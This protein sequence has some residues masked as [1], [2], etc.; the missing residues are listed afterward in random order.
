MERLATADGWSTYYILFEPGKTYHDLH[1]EFAESKA[2]LKQVATYWRNDGSFFTRTRIDPG[3]RFTSDGTQSE[4]YPLRWNDGG[5]DDAI[6]VVVEGEKAAV[7]LVSNPNIDAIYRIYS[8]GPLWG[9]SK[10]DFSQLAGKR[11]ILW[12]DTNH[13][14]EN[15]GQDTFVTNINITS[16]IQLASL[17]VVVHGKH[18]SDA[19]DYTPEHQEKLLYDAIQVPWEMRSEEPNETGF[20][21]ESAEEMFDYLM[22]VMPPPDRDSWIRFLAAAKAS[23]ITME[24]AQDWSRKDNDKYKQRDWPSC[25][26]SLTGTSR[27][28]LLHLVEEAGVMTARKRFDQQQQ[29]RKKR[30]EER[31]ERKE[32]RDQKKANDW[33]FSSNIRADR[34]SKQNVLN[35]LLEFGIKDHFR[36]NE[37][38]RKIERSDVEFGENHEIVSL[39]ASFE[40]AYAA[41]NWTP[42]NQAI[43]DGVTEAAHEMGYNPVTEYLERCRMGW[44]SAGRPALLDNLAENAFAQQEEDFEDVDEF[45]LS[46]A[47]AALLVRGQVV[48]ALH[49]G[50]EF[51]YMPVLK[52]KQGTGKGQSLKILAIYRHVEGL[53]LGGFDFQRKIQERTRGV[54]IVEVAEFSS[55]RHTELDKLKAA[56]SD[57]SSTNR[58]SYERTAVT[59]KFTHIMVATTNKDQMFTDEEHRRNPVIE[60]KEGRE[61]NLEYLQTNKDLLLGEAAAEFHDNVFWDPILRNHVVA[62]PKHLWKTAN[63]V[64]ASYEVQQPV[65]VVL[66]DEWATAIENGDPIPSKALWDS[67]AEYKGQF[68]TNAIVRAM[69]QKHGYKAVSRKNRETGKAER[70]WIRGTRV[71]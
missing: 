7:A 52:S 60:I 64:A 5:G 15:E 31:K 39:G 71:W 12:L 42:T 38:T 50:A 51:Q 30:S 1:K 63:E 3:K 36:Y 65:D 26:D 20:F 34:N 28:T 9:F 17:Q 41:I 46:N 40:Q 10:A 53:D 14:G 58:E 11:V 24:E 4:Y 57:T 21:D 45:L 48:R 35:A 56:T 22:Q 47:I 70:V 44:M 43:F 25:W 69:M 29:D 49:P 67:V 13:A 62:L 33:I 61:I 2:P 8:V 59:R 32:Y 23:G 68:G 19:A 27:A 6:C 55:L 16:K 18:S 37:W 66:L 54:N